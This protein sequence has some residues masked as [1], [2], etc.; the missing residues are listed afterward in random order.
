MISEIKPEL[1]ECAGCL[2]LCAGQ[3]TGCKAAA[4]AIFQEEETC[5]LLRDASN[6]FNSL[7]REAMLYN[8]VS[9]PLSTY[10]NNCY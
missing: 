3:K 10:I 7:N 6:A 1:A 8:T 5:V 9:P 4:H 2:Q